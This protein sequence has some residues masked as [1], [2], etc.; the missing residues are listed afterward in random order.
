MNVRYI[1]KWCMVAALAVLGTNLGL[2]KALAAPPDPAAATDGAQVLTRGPVHEAFAETVTFDPL[3]GI[4]AP[5]APP[6]AIEELPPDQRL[7]GANVAWIPGYWAWDDER[8]D[9]L[10]V[11][12]IWRDLPPGRQWVP[13][14]WGQSGQGYQWTSGY[15]ADAQASNVQYLPEPP[16][17]AEAGP[18]IPAPSPDDTWLPGSWLWQ[19]EP[20]CLA[21][22]YL[23]RRAAGLGV[24]SRPLRLGPSRLRFCRRLLGL[25]HRPPRR[26]VCAGV[27]QW[28]H[29]Y[30]ARFLLLACDGDRPGRV[31]QLSLPAAAIPALLFR[32][33]LRRQLPGRGV[34]PFVF[35]QLRPS[36]ATIRFSP[37]S[38]GS[39]ARTASGSS[40]SQPTSRTAAITRMPDR[41]G[42]GRP[43][44]HS[45][46]VR[47]R[48]EERGPV[49]AVPFS[50]IHEESEQSAAIPAGRSVGAT[51]L[52][53]HGQAVQRFREQRQKLENQAAAPSAAT[54]AKQLAPA[55]G[56]LPI[57]PIVARSNAD[58]GKDHIPPQVHV[59]PKPDLT[60]E[61]K[62]R[63]T[64]S[65]EQ[66]QPRT[67]NRLPLDTPKPEPRVERP[68]PKREP[69]VE[70]PAHRKAEPRVERPAPQPPTERPA[71]GPNHNE[72]KEKVK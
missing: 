12:G 4:V 26:A 34:L 61:A 51:K 16:A 56:R 22:R 23:G 30:A 62:P 19:S 33:L 55:T 31:H 11:S 36:M 43:K 15:W 58:L 72:P 25:L 39:I 68:A 66:P 1:Y 47:R 53:Q 14:Y 46:P 48:P 17:T 41:R 42:P 32:R 37:T 52:V 45:A 57:S 49:L 70:R 20:L 28:G 27:F 38:A 50:A 10:W 67:V 2:H 29:V 64:P 54:A 13:G 6:A 18:N 9:F 71:A 35:V 65:P 8:S 59:A 40:A 7:A 69:R 21:S 60:V 63:A 5:K 3:P 44:Q 24:G